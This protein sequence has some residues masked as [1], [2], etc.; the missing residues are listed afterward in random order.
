MRIFLAGASGAIGRL[1]VELLLRERFDI[2]GMT[3]SQ[4]HARWLE[5]KGARTA[6]LDVYER[7]ALRDALITARPDVVISQLTDLSAFD[8]EANARLRIE[9]TASLVD[10]ALA[11]GARRIIAQ[12]IS[13]AYGPGTG[14]AREDEPL[15]TG[16]PP[17][18]RRTIEGVVSLEREVQRLPESVILRYGT[19]YGPGTWFDR[20]GV[21]TERIRRGM[22][23]ATDGVT[24]FVHVE[25]AARAAL[26]A[27]GWKS[28]TYNIVDD[29]P[30]PGG[31]WIP[32]LARLV[33]APA[34]EKAYGAEGYERG[35]SNA[36]ARR[37]LGWRPAYPSW[38]GGFKKEF[39]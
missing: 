25:D 21:I 24:S 23:K 38:R 1:L 37:E 12:S 19:L 16:A 30:A 14:P 4:E 3:R 32:Y 18:R 28:G 34:P 10:G 9:G 36:K 26:L 5:Q 13:F 2:V 20:G 6:L 22:L 27:I 33:G 31:E 7:D 8:L 35:A 29:E 39:E 11:A 15:D 17:P